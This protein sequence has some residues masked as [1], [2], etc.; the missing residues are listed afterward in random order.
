MIT[1]GSGCSGIEAASVAW[2]P[3]G[4]KPVWFSQFDPEHD[5]SKGP[6]YPSAV[7][8]HHWPHIPNL[9]DLTTV[10]HQIELGYDAP[11]VF[12]AGTPCQ[13]YSVAGLR[14]GLADARGALTLEYVKIL[15]TIDEQRQEQQKPACIG[16]WENVPGV[17]SSADNA[18]GCLLGGLAGSDCELEPGPRPVA[19]KGSRIWRWCEKTR[20]HL[21]RWTNAGCVFGPKRTVAWRVI[22]AQYFGVAQRRRRVFVVASARYGF[23]PVEVLLEFEG[24]RRDTPPIRESGSVVAAPTANGVGTCGADDNQGQAGR[25]IPAIAGTL[26]ANGKAAGS[27]TQQ[28]AE[29]GMLVVH[30]TQ[31]PDINVEL[32]HTLG[33]NQGQENAVAIPLLEVGKRTGASTTDPRAGIG[34]G[35]EGDPMFTLQ[36]GAPH[37]VAYSVSLRGRDGGA[38]AELGGEVSGCLR[39]SSGG[40]DKPHVLAQCVTGDITHTLKAEG[41]DASED[42]TGRGQP[43]VPVAFSSKD[44]GGDATENMSPTLRACGHADSHANGGAPPAVA[45][46]ILEVGMAVR[47]LTPVE[48]ERL[49]GFPDGYTGIPYRGKPAADGHRYKALGNSKAIPVVAWLGKRIKKQ[50][51]YSEFDNL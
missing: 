22:D 36:A 48:C 14:E 24:L 8:Q 34:V 3:I 18:F 2:E 38:T 30:G 11:D 4:F 45:Y 46:P 39:A 40:G 42:G 20:R 19:G 29:S 17:L 13:A 1:F 16:V 26:Q 33:R 49:Q 9:G 31:D 43:I 37:G 44:Y 23:D 6:D 10:R 15:D 50:I 35:S 5:Y 28:D 25:L 32:A 7:L 41:F 12:V 51:E 27:A 47:R 21:P